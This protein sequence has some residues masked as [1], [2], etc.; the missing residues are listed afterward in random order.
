MSHW[1][2]SLFH[3]DKWHELHP[4]H[5]NARISVIS[6]VISQIRSR[7]AHFVFIL[8]PEAEEGEGNPAIDF[9]GCEARLGK[10][11]KIKCQM[12]YNPAR[13]IIEDDKL[14]AYVRFLPFFASILQDDRLNVTP[15]DLH[16]KN[17]HEPMPDISVRASRRMT[18]RRRKL[19]SRLM[20]HSDHVLCRR[21]TPTQTREGTGKVGCRQLMSIVFFFQNWA[22]MRW[23][24]VH[25]SHRCKTRR[26]KSFQRA[27]VTR[28]FSIFTPHFTISRHQT[29][30]SKQDL[31]FNL[32]A[33][34]ASVGLIRVVYQTKTWCVISSSDPVAFI[35]FLWGTHSTTTHKQC[36]NNVQ[37]CAEF[38]CFPRV[39]VGF[40]EGIWVPPTVQ[41]QACWGQFETLNCASV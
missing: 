17:I 8:L 2:L 21:T 37:R 31:C 12:P 30:T 26:R 20:W 14:K 35:N 6:R 27:E 4:L 23:N 24:R 5:P 41:N 34:F 15:A 9:K 38:A 3:W 19:F 39:C 7:Q 1:G 10:I 33:A 13:G 16:D 36:L 18:F 25:V 28:E 32:C 40:L 22:V 11:I 29:P